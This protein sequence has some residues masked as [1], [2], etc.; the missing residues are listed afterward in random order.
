MNS[1][2]DPK[3]VEKVDETKESAPARRK[4]SRKIEMERSQFRSLLVSNPNYFGNLELSPFK[5]VNQ[6][7]QCEKPL[8]MNP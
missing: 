1:E 3:E 6:K 2:D 4:P 8:F 7:Q 5:P